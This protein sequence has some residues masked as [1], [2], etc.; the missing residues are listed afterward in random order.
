MQKSFLI[1][2]SN[3]EWNCE[4]MKYAFLKFLFLNYAIKLA[5]KNASGC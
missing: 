4:V 3:C 1:L 5:V 2:V